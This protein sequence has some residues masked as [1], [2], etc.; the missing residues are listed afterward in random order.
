MKLSKYYKEYLIEKNGSWQLM[1]P[2]SSS[3]GLS[4]AIYA[5]CDNLLIHQ[6]TSFALNGSVVQKPDYLTVFPTVLFE[7]HTGGNK[8]PSYRTGRA[9]GHFQTSH[10]GKCVGEGMGNSLS[11]TDK[12]R[13]AIA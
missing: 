1:G 11:R 6:G 12:L 4:S 5:R 7:V 8:N 13:I 2:I 10:S 3:K 9:D